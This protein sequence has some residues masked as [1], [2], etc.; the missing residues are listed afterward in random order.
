MSQRNKWNSDFENK[1][2][3]FRFDSLFIFSFFQH[4]VC[5]A[6]RLCFIE[7]EKYFDRIDWTLF[8]VEGYKM[9]LYFIRHQIFAPVM[10][11]PWSKIHAMSWCNV[12]SQT[13]PYRTVGSDILIRVLFVFEIIS[14][15]I[16]ICYSSRLFQG[17]GQLLVQTMK[18]LFRLNHWIL[19]KK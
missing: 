2:I 11:R 18:L 17:R 12:K 3:S 7:V 19:K 13:K 5:G 14:E 16:I 4:L 1:H 9:F 15:L 6:D 8:T 10:S